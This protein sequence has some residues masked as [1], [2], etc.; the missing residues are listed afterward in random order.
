[1]KG[2]EMEVRSASFSCHSKYALSFQVL[3][4]PQAWG[5]FYWQEAVECGAVL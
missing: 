2:M 1:M 5:E 3:Y 4:W